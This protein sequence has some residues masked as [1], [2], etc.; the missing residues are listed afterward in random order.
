[1]G[2]PVILMGESG[3]G[4]SY[5]MRNMDKANTSIINVLGK[6]LPFRSSGFNAV[7]VKS[8]DTITSAIKSA[9]ADSIIIDDFGY[10]ITDIY[11]RK[12]YGDEKLKDQF[13]VYKEIAAKV[14]GLM[15]AIL[16][17]PDEKVVYMT[18]HTDTSNGRIEPMTIGKLLN[19][20]VKLVGM[21]TICLISGASGDEHWFTTNGT[22]PAKTPPG[23]FAENRIDNDLALVDKAIRDYWGLSASK[24]V[25]EDVE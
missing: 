15:N 2:V 7:K 18:M 22:P 23:M 5:S 13:E 20:K 24:E 12:S 1:M 25:E 11:M 6:P 3:T 9:K 8:I 16:A 14:Y 19:E 4:K 10:T 21:T 17:L